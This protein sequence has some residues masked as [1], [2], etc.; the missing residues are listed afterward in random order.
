MI[1][2]TY[3]SIFDLILS[4]WVEAPITVPYKYV[5]MHRGETMEQNFDMVSMYNSS[6]AWESGG[7]GGWVSV[8][9]GPCPPLAPP[10]PASFM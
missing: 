9:E 10:C 8:W 2:A 4:L 5:W 7:G 6:D 3:S 1:K